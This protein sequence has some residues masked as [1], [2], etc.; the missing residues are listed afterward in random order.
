MLTLIIEK[1]IHMKEM[2]EQIEKLLKEKEDVAQLITSP[3]TTTPITV[4]DTIGDSTSTHEDLNKVVQDLS[5][6][7]QENDRLQ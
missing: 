3:V 1:N 7:R 2:E 4:V 5:L 6:R